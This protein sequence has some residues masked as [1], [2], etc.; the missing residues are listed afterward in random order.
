[1]DDNFTIQ[2]KLREMLLNPESENTNIFNSQQK[3]EFLFHLLKLICIGGSMCQP[4]DK[5]LEWK[6][7]IR[8]IYKDLVTVY[9]DKQGKI[10]ISSKI[11]HIDPRGTCLSLFPRESPYNKCYVVVDSS[12]NEITMLYKRFDPFW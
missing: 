1:M 2:D 3:K 6:N 9:S 8:D 11:Y 7:A 10:R 5:F 4:E 12:K